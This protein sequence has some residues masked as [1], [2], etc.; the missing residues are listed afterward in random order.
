MYQRTATHAK[1]TTGLSSKVVGLRFC[2]QSPKI[3]EKFTLVLQ[4]NVYHRAPYSD[5]LVTIF[6][7]AMATGQRGLAGIMILAARL[8]F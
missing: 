7:S 6:S 5:A 1:K 4:Q 2:R 8:G 3:Q